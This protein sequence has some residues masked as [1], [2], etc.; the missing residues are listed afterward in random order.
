MLQ[1]IPHVVESEATEH[2]KPN[3]LHCEDHI[4]V[5]LGFEAAEH[6]LGSSTVPRRN[7]AVTA[8]KKKTS[9]NETVNK[10][11]DKVRIRSVPAFNQETKTYSFI[12]SW[13]FQRLLANLTHC[14][15]VVLRTR[16][17]RGS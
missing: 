9:A 4:V 11:M 10:M 3:E 12:V 1:S 2:D 13:I 8:I 17:C 7:A 15:H 14:T 16:K 6:F 5:S